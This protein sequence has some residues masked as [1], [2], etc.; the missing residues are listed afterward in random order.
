MSTALTA[1]SGRRSRIAAALLAAALAFAG[2]GA[3]VPA[4]A[5]SGPALQVTEAPRAGGDVTISGTGFNPAPIANGVYVGIRAVG[6]SSDTVLAWVAVGNTDGEIPGMGKTAP[7]NADGSFTVVLPAPAF[8]VGTD[9]VVNTRQAHGGQDAT[10]KTSVPLVYAAPEPQPATPTTTALT[11]S[12]SGTSAEGTAL[13]LTAQVSPDAAG[14]VAFSDGAA[15]VGTPQTVSAGSASVTLSAPAKGDHSFTAAFTPADAAAFAG[16]ASSA[17]AHTVTAVVVPERPTPTVTVGKT[18]GIDPAGETV[19]VTGTG[20]TAAPPATSGTRPPLKDAF[21]GAYVVFGSFLGSWKPSESAPSSARKVIEQKWGVHQANLAAIGGEARGGIV[22]GEDGTFS[23]TLTLR[24]AE[25]LAGGKWGVY[26]YAGG[27]ATYAP[28]ETFTPVSFR[29]VQPE[30]VG[31]KVTVTPSTGLD[32]GVENVLTISGTGFTGASAVNGAYV[33]FGKTSVWQGGG[34][35]VAE[36]WIAQG[37]VMPRQIVNGAFTTT[38]TVPA[39]VLDPAE[40]YQV[41]TSAAHGLSV[42]DR[43]L[44]TF[45]PVTVADTATPV[46]P[47]LELS[48]ASVV[49]GGSITVSGT[50]F[51][52]GAQAGVAVHSD[53]VN[54]GTALVTPAGTFSITATIPASLPAG[55]HTI[56]A[57]AGDVTVSQPVTV[58]AAPAPAAKPDALPVCVARGV[59]GASIDW[60]VKSSFVSYVNGPIAKGSVSGGWGSGSGAY[61]TKTGNGRVAY[62]GSMHFTGHSGALDL[63]L[64]NPRIQ[65]S[66]SQGSLILDVRSKGFNGSPDVDASGVVFATFSTGGASAGGSLRVDGAATVLTDAGAKAFAGFYSSGEA[67]APLSF[68]FPLGAEVPCDTTTDGLAVTGGEPALGAALVG[69]GILAL[70]ALLVLRRRLGLRRG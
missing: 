24:E 17:V 30:P 31:P 39:G 40:S 33:L 34:P 28:F 37:W 52:V 11:V 2:V 29:T 35:L 15:A 58:T 20:F 56:V 68:S 44:D 70:G 13:V 63:T 48:S 16:S 61:S 12:P 14:T 41:A 69:T 21:A 59:E 64:A 42:T 62:S 3:A 23:T 36:G 45:T 51:P 19:T 26:T 7:M 50:G 5:A 49:Q 22:I 55:A 47:A 66:G 46:R 8:Q 43:S 1:G 10:Q 27:G 57:T 65:I 6:A 25:A 53:P 67:L 54:L 60:G 32:A 38:L 4:Q 18:S 9:Y